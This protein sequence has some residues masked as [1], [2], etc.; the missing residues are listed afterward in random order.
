[1][2][3]SNVVV[4]QDMQIAAAILELLRPLTRAQTDRVREWV[5]SVIREENEVSTTSP[6]CR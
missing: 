1:M 3:I 2:D 5:D 6:N 4:H